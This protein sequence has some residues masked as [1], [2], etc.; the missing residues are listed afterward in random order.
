MSKAIQVAEISGTVEIEESPNGMTEIEIVDGLIL[1]RGIASEDLFPKDNE[2]EI[3]YGFPLILL[4]ADKLKD[5]KQIVKILD[6]V[7]PLNRPLLIFCEHLMSDPMGTLV[8][9]VRREE[10]EACAVNIPWMGEVESEIFDDL[11]I[12]TGGTVVDNDKVDL[13]NLTLSM[14][15]TAKK[16]IITEGQT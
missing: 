7:K 10:M 16:V 9:N 8:Y 4:L 3:E 15:G 12:V 1:P 5:S 14:F 11:S 13:E 6:L 2:K